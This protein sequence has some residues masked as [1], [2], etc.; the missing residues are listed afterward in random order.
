MKPVN[1][2]LAAVWPAA[3]VRAISGDI[4]LRWVDDE[5]L[6]DIAEVAVGGIHPPDEMPF[7]TPWTRG[8]PIEITRSVMYWIW[9]LRG[10]T[11]TDK[12]HM[13][14]GVL[15][16]GNAAGLQGL[17]GE[18]WAMLREAETSSWLGKDFQGKGY[19]TRMRILALRAAFDGLGAE[20]V[21][22]GAF[23][24][25]PASNRVSEKVGYEHDGITREVR[26]GRVRT[27]HRY[28]ITR[29]RYES[30]RAMHDEIL[31]AP[32]QL[33]GFEQLREELENPATHG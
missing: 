13:P 20:H 14:L 15:I 12:F 32:V 4:E 6:Q 30:L 24:D 18:H 31:G 1:E 28:R 10:S 29:E 23:I 3:G 26:D 21:T 27:A 22:S 5:L 33:I 16:N 17:Q 11:D 7:N 25:N 8:T 19:G 2:R 9:T